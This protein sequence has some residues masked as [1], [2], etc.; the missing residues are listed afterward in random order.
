LRPILMTSFAFILGVSP[1]V[2]AA[3]AGAEMDQALGTAVFAGMIGV[4]FFGIFLTPVFFSLIMKFSGPKLT[5]AKKNVAAID[6]R[7]ERTS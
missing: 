3:G 4:T 1:L 6:S 5:R 2:V 7:S